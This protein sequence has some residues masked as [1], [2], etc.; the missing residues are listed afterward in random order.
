MEKVLLVARLG[1]FF[2][3]FE[4]NNIKILQSMGY[5]VWCAGNFDGDNHK[6][7]YLGVHK[8]HVH[9]VRSPL[10]KQ[11]LMGYKELVSLMR[12]HDFKLVHCHMPVGAVFA[13]LAA[14]R[15]K[16]KPVIYTAHGLQFCK[17]GPKKDWILFYPTVLLNCSNPYM[18]NW[19]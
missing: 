19:D 11:N 1:K 2:S 9:L 17:A 16:T 13:R 5:E 12:E 6:L 8:V 4:I 7:D 15:T 3:D 10:S 18:M 14:F